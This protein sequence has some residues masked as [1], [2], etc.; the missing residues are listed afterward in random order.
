L[1]VLYNRKINISHLRVFGCTCFVHSQ[2][3]N[4]LEPRARKCIFIGYSSTKK[5]YKCFDPL[6]NRFYFSRDVIFNENLMYHSSQGEQEKYSDFLDIAPA[7]IVPDQMRVFEQISGIQN[8]NA[9]STDPS[10]G[11]ENNVELLPIV[12]TPADVENNDAEHLQGQL[13]RS[14][15]RIRTPSHLDDFITYCSTQ[16]PIQ[17]HIRYDKMSQNFYSFLT[18]IEKQHEPNSFEEASRQGEWV[19]AMNEELSALNKNQT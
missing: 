12:T 13:R 1:E 19:K 17:E 14:N 6:A 7:P 11:T 2:D 18:K 10:V 15:R 5:G 16:F 4:K 8:S 3:E 9:G